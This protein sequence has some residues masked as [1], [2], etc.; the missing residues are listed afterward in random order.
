M[1]LPRFYCS[2]L[3]KISYFFL[4][5]TSSEGPQRTLPPVIKLPCSSALE[6]YP[7][8][9]LTSFEEFSQICVICE[10]CPQCLCMAFNKV[11]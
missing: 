7:R 4:A 10:T 3:N 9:A 8:F 5:I 2:M 1:F 6:Q 11:S